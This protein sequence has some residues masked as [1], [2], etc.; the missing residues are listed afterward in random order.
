MTHRDQCDYGRAAV[1]ESRARKAQPRNHWNVCAISDQKCT[2][3]RHTDETWSG[4]QQCC[5]TRQV[6]RNVTVLIDTSTSID[7]PNYQCRTLMTN[8]SK[9]S[10]RLSSS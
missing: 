6:R 8:F 4:D 9:P 10:N 3:N 1:C 7:V 5:P 2:G